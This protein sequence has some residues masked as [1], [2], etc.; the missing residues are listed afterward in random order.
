MHYSM[1]YSTARLSYFLFCPADDW[2]GT[3]RHG[4]NPPPEQ[5][6]LDSCPW[7]VYLRFHGAGGKYTGAYVPK[8]MA[9]WAERIRYWTATGRRVYTAFNNTDDGTPPSAIA[10]ARDLAAALRRLGVMD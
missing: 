1:I 10:D 5:Y 9:A 3:L 4:P 7:G 6:P 8:R 2:S